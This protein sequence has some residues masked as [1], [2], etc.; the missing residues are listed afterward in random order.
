LSPLPDGADGDGHHRVRADEPADQEH[1][2]G[3]GANPTLLQGGDS[4]DKKLVWEKFVQE[5]LPNYF[6]FYQ[7]LGKISFFT[8]IFKNFRNQEKM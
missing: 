3:S 5:I 4:G 8:M 6:H 2:G 7:F 1:P